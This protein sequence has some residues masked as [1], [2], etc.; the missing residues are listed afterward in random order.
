MTEP[1]Y[2]HQ[3]DAVAKIAFN[4]QVYLGFDPGLG[5]S[6]TSLEA[7]MSR[8]AKRI[9]VICP[10]I[11]RY[12]WEREV[13]KWTDYKALVVKTVGDL[14]GPGVK[15]LT[16]GMLSKKGSPFV[17]AVALGSDYDFTILDEAAYL[18][19]A[20]AKR[21]Q[22]VLDVMFNRLGYVLPLS[23]TPAPNHAGELYTILHKLWPQ[24]IVGSNGQ[25]MRQWQF[26]DRYCVV[27]Q[28][29]FGNGPSVRVIEG[30]KNLEE[31]RAKM[32]G[33]MLRT[34]KSDVL[35][36]LPPIRWDVVPIGVDTSTITAFAAT[37]AAGL[38]D[39]DLLRYLNGKV[40]DEHVMRLRHQLGVAKIGPA[41][42]YIDTFMEGLPHGKKVLVFAHHKLVI[43]GLHAGLGN[44]NPVQVT[45]KNT[46]PERE[47]AVNT[48]LTDRRCRIFIGNI[49][50]AGTM[51]TLV[52]PQCDCSDVIFV[53]SSYS[54]QDNVQA[55]SRVHRI[56]QREA[57]VARMLSARGTI[58]DRIQSIVARKASDFN[59]LFN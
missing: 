58:D 19:S 47:A 43:E 31:L 40:G 23:G 26:E 8:N 16:Y 25:T 37:Q 22:A 54:A 34:K 11:G 1:L 49:A 27:R 41:T 56:G 13:A 57:V 21:T 46:T 28:K 45:G 36:D 32:N 14:I 44:W 48:F 33:F 59:D 20:G 5:K 42:E 35:K 29:R 30:S 55:A 15:I 18:K 51:L 17:K 52:G 39:E 3:T 50:A 10:A 4:E 12:V 24:A 9:L 2:P 7:A 53:E 38:S 6:R